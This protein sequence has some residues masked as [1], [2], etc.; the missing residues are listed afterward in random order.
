MCHYSTDQATW[1]WITLHRGPWTTISSLECIQTSRSWTLPACQ[2]SAC[3]SK[4]RV[5]LKQPL[6]ATNVSFSRIGMEHGRTPAQNR[7]GHGSTPSQNKSGTQA[8]FGDNGFCYQMARS[9][10]TLKT[11]S[12]ITADELTGLF[13]QVGVPEEIVTDCG[14][15]FVSRL[16]HKP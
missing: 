2:I 15:I 16:M 9:H 6:P 12:Q 11:D 5:P 14:I 3:Q 7:D 8:H 4:H 1:Y 10:S 13:T